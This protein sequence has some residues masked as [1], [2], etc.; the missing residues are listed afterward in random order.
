MAPLDIPVPAP[1]TGHHDAEAAAV[2][3][4]QL[5]HRLAGRP[6]ARLARITRKDGQRRAA[7]DRGETALPLPLPN[8]PAAVLLYDSP[9][10]EQAHIRCLALDFDAKKKVSGARAGRE[11]AAAD[12]TLIAAAVRD[13]GGAC[14][15]SSGPT[16]GWHVWI[17]LSEPL[18]LGKAAALGHALC[19]HFPTLDAAPLTN[20]ASGCLRPPGAAHVAGGYQALHCDLPD[21]LAV[22]DHPNRPAVVDALWALAAPSPEPVGESRPTVPPEQRQPL[23]R[24]WELLASTGPT[25]HEYGGDASRARW[26]ITL[27]AVRAAWTADEWV[28]AVAAW[29]WLSSELSTPRRLQLARQEFEKARARWLQRPSVQLPDTSPQTLHGGGAENPTASDDCQ[30]QPQD[31]HRE[32]RK[33][34]AW[35]SAEAR[36]G[37]LPPCTLAV[38]RAVLLFAHAA[39]AT[40]IQVGVR[41]LAIA[42]AVSR[43]TAGAALWSLADTGMIARVGRGVGRGADVWEINLEVGRRLEPARGTIWATRP[44]FR[45]V[46][47]Q[48]AAEVYEA[49]ATAS[50]PL[51]SRQLAG[52]LG[53]SPTTVTR[54]LHELASWGLA[55]GGGRAGWRLGPADP[56]ELAHRLGALELASAQVA[57]FRAE[58][59]AWWE[60]LESRGL[61]RPAK[62]APGMGQIVLLAPA[63]GQQHTPRARG[64]RAGPRWDVA[65]AISTVR[66]VLGGVVLTQ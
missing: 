61:D 14:I 11:A 64:D 17:P 22:L 63:I 30:R 6:A 10:A 42:A 35:L 65:A 36:N 5:A 2:V 28:A 21:A 13:A 23:A 37:G 19:R 56:D 59:R 18:P 4:D 44:V 12:A 20:A 45:V 38:A 25:P 7:Y 46:G 50:S 31:I 49:L 32:L 9:D 51:S 41:A 8:V 39:G 43:T 26:H 58:R 29:P 24:R 40:R 52:S 55:D 48:G 47:G 54:Y 1:I 60:W 15:V 66:S 34:R 62:R 16:G 3:W 57:Q 27:A 33:V 53:R